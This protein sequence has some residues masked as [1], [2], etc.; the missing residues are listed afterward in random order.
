MVLSAASLE[1]DRDG[2]ALATQVLR[3][4]RSSHGSALLRAC[5]GFSLSTVAV[6][7]VMLALAGP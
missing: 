3:T 4:G 2:L 7:G 1:A 6:I 5:L